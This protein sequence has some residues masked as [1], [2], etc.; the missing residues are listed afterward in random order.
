M[1]SKKCTS[2]LLVRGLSEFH[3]NNKNSDGLQS[4]CK[5]CQKAARKRIHRENKAAGRLTSNQRYYRR[6]KIEAL[7]AYGGA[8]CVCCA[9]THLEF[10]G[11]DHVDGGGNKDRQESGGG[12]HFYRRLKNEGWPSGFRV[13]CHNCNQSI[14]AYGYCPHHTPA[15]ARRAWS[16]E[17][18]WELKVKQAAEVCDRL[19]TRDGFITPRSL[20]YELKCDYASS[21]LRI[22]SLEKINNGRWSFISSLEAA[23]KQ[24]AAAALQFTTEPSMAALARARGMCRLAVSRHVTYL[25]EKNEWPFD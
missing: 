23:R 17:S 24:T 14:G 7:E 2:C 4:H 1:S 6:L 25:K 10:L 19:Q 12:Q 5:E 20:E 9:E 21:K 18:E 15:E 22:S 3:K 16:D 8:A 11:L 13:L